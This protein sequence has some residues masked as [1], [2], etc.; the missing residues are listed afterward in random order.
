MP[1]HNP[2]LNRH[3]ELVHLLSIEGLGREH[4][5]HILDT[6]SQFVSVNDRDVKKVPLLLSNHP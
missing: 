3:G 6:A 1:G 5:V 4:L 2:Q